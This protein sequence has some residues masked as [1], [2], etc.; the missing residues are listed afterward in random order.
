M[1]EVITLILVLMMVG[2]F[3]YTAA[4]YNTLQRVSMGLTTYRD[5]KIMVFY[6]VY[7]VIIFLLAS[8]V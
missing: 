3:I 7:I 4:L 8:F 6:I 2:F 5:T 1:P